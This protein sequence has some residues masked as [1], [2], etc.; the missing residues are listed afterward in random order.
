[1]IDENEKKL[2]PNDNVQKIL[3]KSV[4]HKN[5]SEAKPLTTVIEKVTESKKIDF[6]ESSSNNLNIISHID[7]LIQEMDKRRKLFD[8][9][10]FY[11]CGVPEN[12]H[13]SA[14]KLILQVGGTVY[15]DLVSAVTHVVHGLNTTKKEAFMISKHEEKNHTLN[16][17]SIEWIIECVE[18]SKFLTEY[19]DS[20]LIPLL[21]AKSTQDLSPSLQKSIYRERSIQKVEELGK[22]LKKI[23]ETG[24]FITNEKVEPKGFKLGAFHTPSSKMKIVPNEEKDILPS[25]PITW[26]NDAKK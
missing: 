1:M 5:L 10:S 22:K 12:I 14:K 20:S 6:K 23:S 11:F 2:L 16:K 7:K 3:N 13:Q 24:A 17:V 8:G 19:Y 26:L 15:R 9:L 21:E 18:K 4:I 25:I